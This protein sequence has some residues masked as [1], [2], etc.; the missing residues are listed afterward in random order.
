MYIYIYTYI[1]WCFG[2][3]KATQVWHTQKDLLKDG[4][5]GELEYAVLGLH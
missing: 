1:I 3:L 4:E 5:K 2:A